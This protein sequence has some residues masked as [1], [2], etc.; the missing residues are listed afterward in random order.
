ME[1]SNDS[2]YIASCDTLKKLN[3]VTWPNVFNMQ[4]VMLEHTLAIHYVCFVGPQTVA[5]LSE[6]NP[7]NGNQNLFLT[8]TLDAEVLYSAQV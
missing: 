1:L 7:T 6:A 2:K 3:V 4:S 8:K 5:S